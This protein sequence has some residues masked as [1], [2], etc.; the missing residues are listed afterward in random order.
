[1]AAFGREVFDKGGLTAG[2]PAARKSFR[3]SSLLTTSASPDEVHLAE[4]L[5]D[6]EVGRHFISRSPPSS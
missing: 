4:G 3:N 6:D 5:P 1:M 2:R